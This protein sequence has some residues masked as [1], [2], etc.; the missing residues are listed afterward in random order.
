MN[1][2]IS[3]EEL[4]L[5]EPSGFDNLFYKKLGIKC[6]KTQLQAYELAEK[7]YQK[8]FGR[9]KYSSFDSYRNAR[10]KRLTH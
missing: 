9:R 5:L 6:V 2:K 8:A 3:R 1:K 10:N 7:C 4:A